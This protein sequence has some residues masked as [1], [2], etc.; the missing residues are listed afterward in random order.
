MF[1]YLQWS[2]LFIS[3]FDIS[4]LTWYKRHQSRQYLNLLHT[5]LFEI[6]CWWQTTIPLY[7]KRDD[8]KFVI[9]S[10]P[11][12]CSNIPLYTWRL[13][14]SWFYMQKIA[15]HMINFKSRHSTDKKVDVTRLSNFS[16]KVSISQDLRSYNDVVYYCSLPLGHMLSGVVHSNHYVIL[17][18][19]ILTIGMKFSFHVEIRMMSIRRFHGFY[20]FGLTIWCC[21]KMKTIFFLVDNDISLTCNSC[22]QIDLTT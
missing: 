17:G 3:W 22:L 7:N 13:Y 19:M 6:R 11:Y 21:F 14:L 9:V 10:F 1:F 16:F 15:L 5:Y 4:R 8:F 20:I 12:L 2:N 18:T